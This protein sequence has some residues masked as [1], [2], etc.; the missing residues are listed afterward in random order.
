[1]EEKKD[2][3]DKNAAANIG[4]TI[5]GPKDIGVGVTYDDYA[6]DA[7]W[8]SETPCTIIRRSTRSGSRRQGSLKIRAEEEKWKSRRGNG[9]AGTREEEEEKRRGEEWE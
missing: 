9:L 1:M 5:K 2:D 8:T 4:P 3:D 6:G 7:R